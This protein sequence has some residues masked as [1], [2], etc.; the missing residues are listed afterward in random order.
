MPWINHLLEECD[1][2]CS[3]D[4][5]A[6]LLRVWRL[7]AGIVLALSAVPAAAQV[8]ETHHEAS[9]CLTPR[10]AGEDVASAWSRV[11]SFD[12]MRPQTEFG[13]GDYWV[14]LGFAPIAPHPTDPLVL[15]VASVWQDSMSFHFRY[16]DGVQEQLSV[17]QAQASRYLSIGA[18]FE[19]PI[20]SRG[21]ALT[22]ILVE[23]QGSANLRGIFIGSKLMPES[24]SVS[25]KLWLA[26]LYAGFAG[27]C[28]ALLVYNLA[29]WVA[30]RHR[31]QLYYCAMVAAIM[32][33]AFSASGALML[34]FP[35]IDNNTRL[36]I[37]Y[38]TLTMAA[39]TGMLFIRHFFEERVTPPAIRKV[40]VIVVSIQCAITGAFVILSPW[41]I[42]LIDRLYFTGFAGMILLVFP[43]LY[44]AWK[45]RSQFLT[46]F[47]IAWS[48]PLG[49]SFLRAL[50]GINLMPYSFWVDNSSFIALGV[51]AL[52]SSVMITYR[53]KLLSV[54][55]DRARREEIIASRMA[56]TDSLTGLLNRRAFLDLTIGRA[57]LH[58]LMLIDID[59][60]KRIN[61]TVGH[62][63]GD[64]VLRAVAQI[65]QKV[66]PKGALAVRLGG[67]EFGLLMPL[68][69]TSACTAASVLA[70]LRNSPMPFNLR[71]TASLGFADGLIDTEQGWKALYRQAD[72]ALYRAK[73]DGRDR[74]CRATYLPR[75]A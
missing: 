66:R 11:S 9:V 16:A 23:T 59:H 29:V 4:R 2:P 53:I 49:A 33:Y 15:R 22:G 32:A 73:T 8:L 56:N 38:A 50:H 61:D 57:E 36:Q 45:E 19:I 64:D 71:V 75:T 14:H 20:P 65:L 67:E 34:A 42:H 3:V 55:R 35:Q 27:L 41:Q 13:S 63:A 52:L 24:A 21:A 17:S 68:S 72:S 47:L 10:Q 25:S 31:F 37:N 5:G 39:V 40:I 26:T 48:A 70:E 12:C 18:I 58:R 62:D 28:L 51:E 1:Y 69:E 60:F 7:L 6:F 30:L 43:L 54:E 74:A 44:N 46:L